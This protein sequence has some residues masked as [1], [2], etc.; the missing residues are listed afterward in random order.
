M[1]IFPIGA[2]HQLRPRTANVTAIGVETFT[3]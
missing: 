1:F 3:V 2:E